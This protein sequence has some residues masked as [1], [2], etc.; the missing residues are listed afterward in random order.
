MNA[1]HI[2]YPA[3]RR[4]LVP[5]LHVSGYAA[6]IGDT[7]YLRISGR[8][9]PPIAEMKHRPFTVIGSHATG[10]RQFNWSRKSVEVDVA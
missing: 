8:T 10:K 2:Q 6:T 4:N 5:Q 3:Y 7:S 9:L 1:E